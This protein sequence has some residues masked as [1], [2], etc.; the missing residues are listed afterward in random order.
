MTEAPGGPGIPARW[1]SSAKSAVGAAFGR[2]SH[3]WYTVSHGIV[4]EVYHPRI[5]T[6]CTRDLGLLISDDRG[7]F[8]EEK[9][10]A[11]SHVAWFAPGV[12]GFEVTNDLGDGLRTVKEIFSDP[13]SDVL[14][15]RTRVEG[16]GP[17]THVTVLLAPHI[18]NRGSDNVGRVGAYKGVP[19]LFAE[20]TGVALAMAVSTD[21]AIRSVGYVGTS[22]GWQDVHENGHLTWEYRHA[23]PGNVALAGEVVLDA[24]GSFDLVVGFGRTAAEAGHRAKATLRA[25]IGRLRSE[26]ERG[27][28]DWHRAAD[29]TPTDPL[30]IASRTVLRVHESVAF[31]G[32]T[33]ASLSIPWG[34]AK[35]DEDMGGYHLVWPRD[36]VET[37]GGLLATGAGADAVR[38]VEYLRT[39]QESDGHWA[40]NMWL[41]GTAYW[42]GVQMDE[43]ALPVLALGLCRQTG[44]TLDVGDFWPM[45]RSAVGYLVRNGPSTAQDRWE[46]DSGY[47]PFTVAAEVA[48]LAVAAGIAREM[49]EQDTARFLDETARAWNASVERWMYVQGTPLAREVG[50]DGY[51]V[52]IAP[53]DVAEGSSPAWGWVPI[54]NRPP[55]EARAPAGRI[56]SPDALALVRFGLR[57]AHDPRILDTVKVIDHVLRTELPEGPAWRRYSEDGYGEHE[58]GSPFDGTGVGRLWPLLS[59]ERAHYALAAGDDESAAGL[60]DAM[61]RFAG[62]HLLLP[63]Q[64]WDGPDVPDRELH[65]GGP[66]GSAMP[67]VW[68]HSEYLKLARSVRLGRVFDMPIEASTLFLGGDASSDLAVWSPADPIVA[69]APASR[70]RL[71]LPA[72]ATVRWSVDGWVTWQ[73]TDTD[74]ILGVHVVTL[75]TAAVA[76][77]GEVVFTTHAGERWEGSDHTVSVG[78]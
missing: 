5:D 31:P 69:M 29:E 39:T 52:R 66:T 74:E 25:D 32:A 53:P 6:A 47:S 26:F 11:D 36:M 58:D 62:E 7:R 72:E 42:S 33:I 38:G 2:T 3:I 55:G 1:T 64:V 75:P 35:G 54:K 27:W 50:V 51:Y 57:S 13:D 14:I 59:G 8:V 46:E 9:R 49:G 16:A 40:Q 45:V 56:V 41:D 43:T 48:A 37:I 10:D 68:A 4:D 65:P 19:M 12:P 70:L 78:R 67:L 24:S 76:T 20:G 60:R 71:H 22:D 63:E 17:G 21:W 23:G 34:F 77:G 61:R 18:S 15:Q 28:I 30:E 44:A 73:E